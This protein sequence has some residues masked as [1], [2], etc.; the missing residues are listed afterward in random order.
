MG[1]VYDTYDL[2]TPT[3]VFTTFMANSPSNASTSIS[4]RVLLHSSP[5]FVGLLVGQWSVRRMVDPSVGWVRPLVDLRISIYFLSVYQ[6]FWPHSNYPNVLVT[7]FSA[8]AEVANNETNMGN[9]T[10]YAAS[11]SCHVG[12]SSYRAH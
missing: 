2:P 12:R 11:Q 3:L 5:H 8:P 9:K 10:G 1:A 6:F 4:S 7:S